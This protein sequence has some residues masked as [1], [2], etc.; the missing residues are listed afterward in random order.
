[1]ITRRT[2]LGATLAF[3]A[4]ALAQ[5]KRPKTL[6]VVFLRGGVDGLAMVPPIAESALASLR[7]TLVDPAA[8]KLDGM[9]GLHSALAPL[10]PFYE[11]KRL[12]VIHAVG[13]PTP[14]RSHFDAQDFLESG[15]P[16][17]KSADGWLNRAL[18]QLPASKSTLRAIAIQP[19]LPLSLAGPATAIA[20]NALKDFKVGGAGTSFESMYASAVDQALRGA[21]SDAFDTIH[22][23][24]G[25]QLAQQRPKHDAVYPNGPLGKRLQD[26]ARLI[27]ADLGLE[28][29]ATEAGGFDTHL[30]QGPQLTARLSDL[31]RALAAFAQDL[32]P[33]LDDVCV[34]TVTEFG[35]TVRE[36]GSRGTDHGTASAMLVL[37]GR[38][39]GG[40]V[41]ADWPG[42][43][44]LHDGRDLKATTDVRAVLAE[45]LAGHLELPDGAA[46]FPGLA[47]KP[48]QKSLFG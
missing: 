14:S 16:G 38:V 22:T 47:W 34:A 6:V 11:G 1:M 23:L 4:R 45:L 35:R 3:S 36:N 40:R 18:G 21:G 30:A 2:I 19:R 37:G 10:L 32:G 27:H 5:A 13:Q 9:F 41:L 33:R 46:A 20:F 12:A 43:A 26:V 15:T 39:K 44:D 25:Q 7:P 29:A 31:G 42:L 8:L 28:I 17:R 48:S 24:D